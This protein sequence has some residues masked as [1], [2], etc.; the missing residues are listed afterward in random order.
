MGATKGQR[1]IHHTPTPTLSVPLTFRLVVSGCIRNTTVRQSCPQEFLPEAIHGGLVPPSLSGCSLYSTLLFTQLVLESWVGQWM[2]GQQVNRR[3][4]PSFLSEGLEG[5]LQTTV[6]YAFVQRCL[7]RVLSAY[8]VPS[9]GWVHGDV[10]LS[11]VAMQ[12]Y[13]LNWHNLNLKM[14]NSSSLQ[15][16][17]ATPLRSS[18]SP[19]LIAGDKHGG[20]M[21]SDP[22]SPSTEIRRTPLALRGQLPDPRSPSNNLPRTPISATDCEN[23]QEKMFGKKKL[24][25][26]DM[27]PLVSSNVG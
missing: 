27:T 13:M 25:K 1:H 3:T 4:H 19:Q 21:F 14:G 23:Q 22:R 26:G 9:G 10:K 24:F 5:V 20:C 11:T 18:A 7:W 8:C 15:L 12:R 2:H 6:F 17:D 16:D